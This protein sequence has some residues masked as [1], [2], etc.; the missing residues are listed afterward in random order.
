MG[1]PEQENIEQFRQ[2][3]ARLTDEEVDRY[4]ADR[5]EAE[6][7]AALRG[8][9]REHFRHQLGLMLIWIATVVFAFDMGYSHGRT[10][11]HAFAEILV[12]SEMGCLMGGLL[13]MS[14]NRH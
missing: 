1:A 3:L 6:H 12:G 9:R 11:S 4:W 8:R 2:R 13:L 7:Q 14:L 10:L 5:N